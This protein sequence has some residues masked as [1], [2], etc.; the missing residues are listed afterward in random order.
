MNY[1][2]FHKSNRTCINNLNDNYL[3]FQL[4]KIINNVKNITNFFFNK[5]Q[6]IFSPI[7]L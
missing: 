1:R 5:I 7:S 6:L 2:E 3:Y 4:N